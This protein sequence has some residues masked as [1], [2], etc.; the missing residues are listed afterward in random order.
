LRWLPGNNDDVSSGSGYGSAQ[1]VKLA[2]GVTAT[3]DIGTN[4]VNLGTAFVLGSGMSGALTKAGTGTLTLSAANSFTGTTTISAGTLALGAS[5]VLSGGT[6]VNLEGGTLAMG[7]FNNTVHAL[8]SRVSVLA[9]GTWGASGSGA[10]HI[11]ADITG[12]GILTVSTGGASTSAVT[13]SASPSTYGNSVTFTN[14]VTGSSGDGSTPS[15]T[16]TFYDGTNS[17]GTGTLVG[18]A[19]TVSTY[20]LTLNTLTATT[21]SITASYAGNASYDVSTSGVLSQVVNPA[22]SRISLP[23]NGV[24]SITFYGIPNYTY[25]VQ[26]TTNLTVPWW[27]LSTNTAST[28]GSWQFTD[29]NATNQ[30]QYYRSRSLP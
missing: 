5:G 3:L 25:V 28:N 16:V 21:H 15:G 17:I 4:N 29:P 7:S 19:G 20:T 1:Q 13:S 26:T 12:S 6:T 18:S 14:T 2:D 10:N 22:T 27:A 11:S 23:T 8:Q 9:K 24:V 30:Q